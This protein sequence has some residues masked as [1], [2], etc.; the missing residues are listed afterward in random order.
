MRRD[1]RRMS[2]KKD[3]FGWLARFPVATNSLRRR[4]GGRLEVPDMDIRSA[5]G[6]MVQSRRSGNWHTRQL[7]TTGHREL[8]NVVLG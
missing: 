3:G 5:H 1:E 7:I 6:H 4:N 2:V 8:A